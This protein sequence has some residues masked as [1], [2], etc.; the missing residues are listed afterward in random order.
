METRV[1]GVGT[2]VVP[3]TDVADGIGT[4]GTRYARRIF[5]AGELAACTTPEQLAQVYAAKE[6]VAKA[7]S[8]PPDQGLP[9]TCI[10]VHA[11]ADGPVAVL[12]DPAAARQ[13]SLGVTDIHISFARTGQTAVAVA[14]ASRRTPRQPHREDQR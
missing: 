2:D 11:A 1:L 12:T 5:T 3:A 10:E 7:L 9:W 13:E 8:W 14:I 6:A 4:F